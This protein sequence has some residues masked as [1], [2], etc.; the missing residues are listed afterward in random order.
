MY[1]QIE[2]ESV[3]T[4][5]IAIA[6]IPA[7]GEPLRPAIHESNQKLLDEEIALRTERARAKLDKRAMRKLTRRHNTLSKQLKR[8]GW[9]D[10][11]VQRHELDQEFERLGYEVKGKTGA[12]WWRLTMR[13]VDNRVRYKKL[14]LKI[15]HLQPIADEFESIIQRFKAHDEVIAFERE[16][17]EN[18]AAFER[19]AYTWQEQ[20]KATMRRSKRLHHA[21]TDSNGD[22]FCHIPQFERIIFKDDRVLYQI[23]I[24]YQNFIDRFFGRWQDTL[25]YDVD[26]T[27]LE[28]EETLKNLSAGCNRVV[29]VVRSQTGQNFFYSISRL[30][31]P[32]GIPNKQLYGK[33]IEFYPVKDHA[34]TPWP[35]GT[36]ENRKVEWADFETFPHL[37][38][39]GSTKGGK[40]NHLNQM[41]ATICT[42]NTPAE[43]GIL[44]VDLKGGI[45][46]T[47]WAG[48]KHQ[49]RPMVKSAGQVL[50]ALQFMRN[51]MERRLA[52]FEAIRAKNLESFNGKVKPE[53]KLPRLLIV[54]DEMATLMGLG[55]LTTA[56]HEELRVLSSQG[57]AVGLHLVLCTQ[58]SSVDILPGWV[59]TNMSIR[60]STSMPTDVASM[61]I[62][63]TTT[64]AKIPKIPGRIVFSMGR[65]EVIVQSPFI[66]DEEIARAVKISQGFPDSDRGE[67][68]IEAKAPIVHPKEKFSKDELFEIVLTQFEGKISA[69]NVFDYLG[70]KENDVITL[71]QLRQMVSSVIEI[72]LEKG[73]QYGEHH[74][75]LKKVPGRGNYAMEI[76]QR[77]SEPKTDLDTQEMQALGP[78]EHSDMELIT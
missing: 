46:F 52:Q 48:L 20:M 17:A 70:G 45:E 64:A 61:V 30:D 40:S 74:Y 11:M 69:S 35:M 32:N 73:I 2:G 31:A 14:A 77:P 62:L 43:V 67:F 76:S 68:A 23:R 12:A 22:Y 16:D 58:H 53:N 27:D 65:D 36:G 25:P 51:I 33:I 60:A 29:S 78:L 41:I 10:L 15:Q 54:I 3:K 71:R 39:A 63:G 42:H 24:S 7:P 19:E 26:I 55:I 47:H 8:A 49:V 38:L 9:N 75:K 34:K 1:L 5:E 37:L 6:D 50:D 44:L 28:C 72:G 66:S 4:P 13:R 59:K 57:R 21:G 18:R 56:I